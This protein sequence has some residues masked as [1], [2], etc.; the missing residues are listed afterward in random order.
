MHRDVK[1]E[2]CLIG[3]KGELRLTDFGFA[4][5]Y[6]YKGK[7]RLLQRICGTYPYMAPEVMNNFPHHAEPVDIWS[8]GITFIAILTGRIFL[9]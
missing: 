9:L 6:R 7:A 1:P 5:I 8:A 4:T 2:N 3:S